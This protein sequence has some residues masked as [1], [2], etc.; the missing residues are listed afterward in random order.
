MHLDFWRCLTT[1]KNH[2]GWYFRFDAFCFW[3]CIIPWS[4]YCWLSLRICRTWQKTDKVHANGTA[5]EDASR[6]KS[7]AKSKQ[8]ILS[9]PTVTSLSTRLQLSIQFTQTMKRSGDSKHSCQSPTPTVDGCDLTRRK[10]LSGIQWFYSYSNRWPSTPWPTPA[11]RPKA[12][13]EEPS[14]ILSRGRQNMCRR[15]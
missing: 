3:R 11:T 5:S 7:S 15:L 8:L 4:F 2:L 12:F 13:H 14:H 6:T 1:G 9:I 10:L